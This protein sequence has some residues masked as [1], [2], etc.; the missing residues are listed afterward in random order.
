MS[1]GCLAD[2]LQRL[3]FTSGCFLG[4]LLSGLEKQPC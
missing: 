1:P 4:P 2:G 3:D